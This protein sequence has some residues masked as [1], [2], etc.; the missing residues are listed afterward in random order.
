MVHQLPPAPWR[1]EEDFVLVDSSDSELEMVDIAV[2]RR[3]RPLSPLNPWA[4]V[5]APA[6]NRETAK[7][8][9][10]DPVQTPGPLNP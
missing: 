4:P 2:Q 5:F 3:R 1:M 7:G 9:A 8:E 6:G 10:R